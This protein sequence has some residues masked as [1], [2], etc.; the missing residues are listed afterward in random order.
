MSVCLTFLLTLRFLQGNMAMPPVPDVPIGHII[1]MVYMWPCMVAYVIVLLI[2]VVQRRKLNLFRTSYFTLTLYQ[3]SLASILQMTKKLH[4]KRNL[5]KKMAFWEYLG[6]KIRGLAVAPLAIPLVCFTLFRFSQM[7][8]W[9][10]R[11]VRPPP[12]G[13]SSEVQFLPS[14]QDEKSMSTVRNRRSPLEL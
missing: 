6:T 5:S 7:R 9:M 12:T 10:R 4:G 2:I 11:R 3:V 13:Y 1:L 8:E 14:Y